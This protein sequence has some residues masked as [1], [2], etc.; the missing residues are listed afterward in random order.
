[1]RTLRIAVLILPLSGCATSPIQLDPGAQAVKV[2]KSDPTDNFQEIGPVSGY[3]G[4]G[5]GLYGS[6]GTYEGAVT[7]LKNNAHAMGA[8]FVQIFTINEPSSEPLCWD[9]QYTLSGTAYRK[10]RS[11]PSPMPIVEERKEKSTAERLLELQ[12]LRSRNLI[13]QEEY[14]GWLALALPC[15]VFGPADFSQ[16]PIG[17]NA[18]HPL[19][20]ARRHLGC[21]N[22][23]ELRARRPIA[24][25]SRPEREG[26]L[27]KFLL[28]G[29]PVLRAQHGIDQGPGSL[30][31]PLHQHPLAGV[32][33][34]GFVFLRCHMEELRPRRPQAQLLGLNAAF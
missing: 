25:I 20:E 29:H 8:D 1:M 11:A 22:E 21:N 4:Q 34:H 33:D 23:Q 30:I 18:L 15:G 13:T 16:P 14:E 10:V 3:N 24:V 27:V 12:D 5:C 26:K 6:L 7:D 17:V 32:P 28:H 2:A 9:N 31:R 19:L